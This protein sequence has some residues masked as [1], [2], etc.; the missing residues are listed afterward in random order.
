MSE[1]AKSI[2]YTDLEVRSFLPSGWGIHGRGGGQWDPRE[3]R[4][5]IEVYDGADNVWTIEV[6]GRDAERAGRHEALRQ[7]IDRIQRRALGR[8]SVLTG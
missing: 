2:V 4:W 5:S 6:A 3:G 8:K 1:N 7:A